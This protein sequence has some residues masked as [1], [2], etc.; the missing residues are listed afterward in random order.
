MRT[1]D[2]LE[3]LIEDLHHA[4]SSHLAFSIEV[5]HFLHVWERYQNHDHSEPPVIADNENQELLK[6]LL[7]LKKLYIY[8]HWLT[9]R[10]QSDTFALQS[11]DKLETLI[12]ISLS[13]EKIS[14]PHLNLT[15]L[16][17]K[18]CIFDPICF[19]T[20][21]S[22][23]YPCLKKL[24]ISGN[25]LSTAINFGSIPNVVHLNLSHN[26]F[27]Y[28][29]EGIGTL[30]FLATLNLSYN[31]ITTIATELENVPS[32]S[33]LNLRSNRLKSLNGLENFTKLE[34]I[35]LSQ[36]LICSLHEIRHI[37]GTR[38]KSLWIFENPI[39]LKVFI[40]NSEKLSQPF[41]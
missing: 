1:I 22:D 29:P 34:K 41:V 28:I 33:Q 18:N 25:R 2:K 27:K 24:D 37:R 23:V 9:N 3:K 7:D 14:I 35:D 6:N 31:F 13:I 30:V 5:S 16:H 20:L 12:I 40:F 11:L 19:E 38:I 17:L 4:N 39:S 10:G 36:N 26:E 32:C 15:T 21:F 8:K